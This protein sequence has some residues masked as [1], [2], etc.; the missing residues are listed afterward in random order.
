M[1]RDL[2]SLEALE[3]HFGSAEFTANLLSD[4]DDE[5]AG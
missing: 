2:H 1:I 4:A 3:I 5:L